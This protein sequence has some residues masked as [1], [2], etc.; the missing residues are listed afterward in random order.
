M[1]HN[2][3]WKSIKTDRQMTQAGNKFPSSFVLSKIYLKLTT[4]YELEFLHDSRLPHS[5]TRKRKKLSS[6]PDISV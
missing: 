4:T 1:K 6:K 2:G 3:N 5:E